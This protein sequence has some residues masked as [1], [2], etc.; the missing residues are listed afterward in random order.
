MSLPPCAEQALRQTAQSHTPL[1]S[2][3]NG[4]EIQRQHQVGASMN[5]E[6]AVQIGNEGATVRPCRSQEQQVERRQPAERQLQ[7]QAQQPFWNDSGLPQGFKTYRHLFGKLCEYGNLE[8]AFEKARKRKTKKA[9][10][11][12][13]EKNLSSE[14]FR[15]QWELLTG[16][17]QPAPLTT[18]I[19]RDPKTR[20]ISA[21]HFRDR[22]VHHAICNV[23]EPIFEPRFIHDTFANR[24]GKGTSGILKRFDFFK[25]KVGPA[26]FVLKADIRHY[27]ETVDQAVLLEILGRR[28][29][30][31]QL[32][33]LISLILE[34]HHTAKPGKG[35]PL[36]NLTSQFFANV[37]L[38][39]FDHFVKHKL[40]ARFYL[41]YVDDFVLLSKNR[42]QLEGWKAEIDAYL[43]NELKIGLHPDKTQIMPLKAG[44]QLVGFRAFYHHRLLKRSNLRRFW[45]RFERNKGQLAAGEITQQHMRLSLAGSNGYLLMG[46]T[47]NLRQE[48]AAQLRGVPQ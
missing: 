29:K 39:E 13:F 43:L 38:G 24:K 48:I 26:G 21:S 22:V 20:K 47:Y 2:A 41:R 30:D 7:Q 23:I 17:Y 28:I 19:V 6:A 34:N 44:V 15:L 10:V 33:S 32:L 35:M 40:H 45:R 3:S 42:R 12:H 16:T 25:R 37:Y 18:F 36:G 4:H 8:L 46:N 31:A 9:Y 27:F 1:H 5:R 14:L 11:Q